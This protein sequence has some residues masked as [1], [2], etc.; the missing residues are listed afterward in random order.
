MQGAKLNLV[1]VTSA[2]LEQTVHSAALLSKI[3]GA[4]KFQ[5]QSNDII[6]TLEDL[7][8]QF[9]QMKKDLDFEEH[10]INSAFEKNR[11]ALS[12]E[13]KFAEKEK[14]EKEAIVEDKTEQLEAAKSDRD[15]E[16]ADMNADNQFMD[17][18]TK[19]CEEKAVLF[20]QRSSTRADEL[21]TLA[22]ATKK[23]QEGAV[24]NF[25]ANKKLVGLNQKGVVLG[26]SSPVSFVQI[27][28]VQHEK[29]SKGASLQKVRSYINDVAER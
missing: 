6:A 8:A 27:N 12:N 24:P 25:E 22:E 11:L 9:K 19:D 2:K 13:K 16:T 29:S 15:E 23:L 4:P 3:D 20:D 18:L 17:V 10:D 26:K 5:Y 14:A 21:S 7:L 28:N 1:Q